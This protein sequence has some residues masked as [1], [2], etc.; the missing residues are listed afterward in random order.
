MSPVPWRKSR[1]RNL[2]EQ[3]LLNDSIP[4]NNDE[5]TSAEVYGER[6]EFAEHSFNA[7]PRR[8]QALR[9]QCAIQ[10]NRRQDDIA[11]FEND[12]RFRERMMQQYTALPVRR[13]EGSDVERLLKVDITHNLH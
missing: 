5:M 4:I 13:W 1:A 3:D 10:L 7:F 9:D 6:P 11:A 2:L 8:L 12:A